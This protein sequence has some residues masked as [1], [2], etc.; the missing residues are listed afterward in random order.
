MSNPITTPAT[1]RSLIF[2]NLAVQCAIG[3]HPHER[4]K[5]QRLLINLAI[6]LDP[7]AEPT[8]DNIADT[9]DYDAVR[10]AIIAIASERHYDL[11]ETLARRLADHIMALPQVTGVRVTTAKPDAYPDCE[12]VAYSITAGNPPP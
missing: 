6:A 1:A 10:T 2:T 12:A 4:A 7:M 3:I 8:S 11:Q 9:L 5:P